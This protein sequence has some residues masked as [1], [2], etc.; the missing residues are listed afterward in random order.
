MSK[1]FI[2]NVKIKII[3]LPLYNKNIFFDFPYHLINL[4]FRNLSFLAQPFIFEQLIISF[5]IYCQLV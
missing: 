4:K 3:F 2:N 1:Y 5:S